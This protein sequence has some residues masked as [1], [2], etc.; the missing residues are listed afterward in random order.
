MIQLL[1]ALNSLAFAADPH[2]AG[3]DH[4]VHIPWSSLF[5]QAFNVG[6]LL[7]ILFVVLRKSAVAHFANRAK[8]Y[9]ELVQRSEAAKAEAERGHRAIKERLD[10]LESGAEASLVQARREADELKLKLVNEARTVAERLKTEAQRT[11]ANEVEK[12]KAELRADL[13]QSALATSQEVLK[14][15]LGASEQAKLQSEFVQKIQVVGQ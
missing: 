7:V 1:L 12:A 15:S 14:S 5:V 8:E 4:A 3:G 2:A 9:N 6:I 10:K 13:L 11:V